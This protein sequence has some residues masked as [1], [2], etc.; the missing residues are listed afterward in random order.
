MPMPSSAVAGHVICCEL[1][2][3]IRLQLEAVQ[4]AFYAEGSSGDLASRQTLGFPTPL[5]A[6]LMEAGASLEREGMS[7]VRVIFWLTALS[8]VE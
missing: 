3:A 8:I 7:K 6:T 1:H 4:A 5:F 2:Y